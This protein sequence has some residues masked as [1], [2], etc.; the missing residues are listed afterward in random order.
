MDDKVKEKYIKAGRIAAEVREASRELILP[1]ANIFDV[2]EKIEK[3]IRDRGAE[4]A[5]PVNISI[6]DVAAHY[7]PMNKDEIKIKKGDVVKVDIGTHVDGYVGDTAYTI[8]LDKKHEK[9]VEAS[10]ERG[11]ATRLDHDLVLVDEHR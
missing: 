6:N 10:Q 9:L 8:S 2:A 5:F 3:M 1:D 7:T 11:R 4:P